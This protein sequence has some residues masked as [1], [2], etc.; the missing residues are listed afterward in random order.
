[1][2][3]D[4]P[5]CDLNTCKYFLDFNCYGENRYYG[6]PHAYL[7]ELEIKDEKIKDAVKEYFNKI[8]K[9]V[10]EEI[11]LKS[12]I[13]L[14]ELRKRSDYLSVLLKDMEDSLKFI[15]PSFFED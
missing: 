12:N 6:C 14:I 5:R 15:S 8:R 1:M 11:I 2:R 3:V 10:R 9:Y 4:L 7:R 13:D